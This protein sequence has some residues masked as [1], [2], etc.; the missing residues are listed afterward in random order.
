[1]LKFDTAKLTGAIKRLGA[2]KHVAIVRSLKR[3]AVSARTAIQREIARDLGL[4]VGVVR[5]AIEINE[6]KVESEHRILLVVAGKHAGRIRLIHFKARGPEPSRGRGKGVTAKLPPPGSGR[7]PRAFI[8]TVRGSHRGVFERVGRARMPIRELRGPS[9]AK[10]FMKFSDVGLRA[11]Q[12]SLVKNL[13]HEFKFA[14]QQA[15]QGS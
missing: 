5:D 11:G 3:A 6:S 14:I 9:I 10:V 8:T 2:K 15:S 4:P 1:M 7:Y 12:E 13:Q